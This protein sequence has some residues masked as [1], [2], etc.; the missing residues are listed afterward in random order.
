M[1]EGRKQMAES[2]DRCHEPHFRITIRIGDERWGGIGGRTLVD[3]RPAAYC[4][5]PIA[6]CL[7]L[8]A[9]WASGTPGTPYG[10][11]YLSAGEN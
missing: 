5:L 3:S 7:L 9:A 1:A 4:L 8:P 10:R 11:V 2:W 6:F